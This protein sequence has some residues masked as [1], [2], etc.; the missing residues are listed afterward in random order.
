MSVDYDKLA[1]IADKL[2]EPARADFLKKRAEC[3]QLAALQAE[4]MA[5]AID[6]H[7]ELRKLAPRDNDDDDGVLL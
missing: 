3:E 7:H 5:K 2:P 1:R 6:A 4:A